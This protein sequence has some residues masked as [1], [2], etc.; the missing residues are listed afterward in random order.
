MF[1][2]TFEVKCEFPERTIL[3]PIGGSGSHACTPGESGSWT[4]PRG[5]CETVNYGDVTLEQLTALADE[6]EWARI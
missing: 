1:K 5:H 4:E 2:N 3:Q 6:S